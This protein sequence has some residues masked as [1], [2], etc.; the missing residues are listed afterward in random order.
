MVVLGL[1]HGRLAGAQVA[2]PDDGDWREVAW[3]DHV[4]ETAMRLA[5]ITGPCRRPPALRRATN[6]AVR[7]D[8]SQARPRNERR[9]QCANS[10]G[11]KHAAPAHV[12]HGVVQALRLTLARPVHLLGQCH[13]ATPGVSCRFS[14]G[15]GGGA[16]TERPD[17][18]NAVRQRGKSRVV[19]A[20]ASLERTPRQPPAA[21]GPRC[22]S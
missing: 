7:Q 18:A 9:A 3:G 10:R 17:C 21:E 14:T 11:W 1:F 8:P 20:R 16:G 13:P 12:T 6:K 2:R 22:P 4:S 5:L 15:Q 19:G